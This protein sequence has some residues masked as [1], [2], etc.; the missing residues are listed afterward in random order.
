[1]KPLKSFALIFASVSAVSILSACSNISAS[2]DE[3]AYISTLSENFEQIIKKNRELEKMRDTWTCAETQ[4][5][6]NY[7]ALIDTLSGLYLDLR[8]VNPTEKYSADDYTIDSW[9]NEQITALSQE[10]ALIQYTLDHQDDSAYQSGIADILN[11]YTSTYDSI[12]NSMTKI[13][14]DFR[15]G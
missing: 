5:T 14:T 4:T 15:N 8:N 11:I 1:M 2:V 9:C 13:K 10:K 12:N 3:N 7:L 6:K